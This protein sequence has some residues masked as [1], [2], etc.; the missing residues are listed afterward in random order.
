MGWDE[1]REIGV[2]GKGC[3]GL[4]IMNVDPIWLSQH[5]HE[6]DEA[7]VI[8][9]VLSI[10]QPVLRKLLFGLS[11]VTWGHNSG[12]SDSQ[13]YLPYQ[14]VFQ[15]QTPNFGFCMNFQLFLPRNGPRTAEDQ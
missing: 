8:F 9:P 2:D 11:K 15:R 4:K 7:H 12:L 3:L 6:R 5:P 1:V 10:M 14:S 13:E